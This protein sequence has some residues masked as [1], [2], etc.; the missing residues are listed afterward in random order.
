[1]KKKLIPCLYLQSE[2]AVTGFGQRNLLGDGDVEKLAVMN[3]LYLTS[4]LRTKSM[5]RPSARSAT[6]VQLLKF[7]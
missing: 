5:T 1:M 4:P 3:C 2:K 6:F 7:R